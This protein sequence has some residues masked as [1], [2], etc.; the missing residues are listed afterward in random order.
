M[1]LNRKKIFEQVVRFPDDFASSIS[2][3]KNH[4]SLKTCVLLKGDLAAGKTTFVQK[5][6]ESY[7]LKGA[8]SPTFS[9]HQVYQNEKIKIDH[10]DL[11]RLATTDEMETSG[12]WEVL[13]G[14]AGLVFIEWPSRISE[15]DLPLHWDLFEIELS[16]TTEI[17]R[18]VTLSRLLR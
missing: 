13:S 17:H 8:T 6:C 15:A 4:M 12:L 14:L 1:S 3:L 2:E 16:K 10:F 7:N 18:Q 5:F 9:L 11:Y